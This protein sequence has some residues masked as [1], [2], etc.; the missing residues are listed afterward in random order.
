MSAAGRGWHSS[1][2]GSDTAPPPGP[3]GILKTP[4]S[5]LPPPIPPITATSGAVPAEWV[6]IVFDTLKRNFH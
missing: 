1:G 5:A 4:T 6:S 3:R 2:S